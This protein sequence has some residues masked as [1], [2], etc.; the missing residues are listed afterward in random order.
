MPVRMPAPR[1]AGSRPPGRG[2]E[3][4]GLGEQNLREHHRHRRPRRKPGSW[5]ANRPAA[6]ALPFPG[7]HGSA[8]ECQPTRKNMSSTLKFPYPILVRHHR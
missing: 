5:Y 1:R 3:S 4:G 2:T 6:V 8:R 7:D